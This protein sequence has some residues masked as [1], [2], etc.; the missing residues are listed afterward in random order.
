MFCNKPGL[1]A[2]RLVLQQAAFFYFEQMH[3][4]DPI[5]EKESAGKKIRG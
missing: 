1:R 5:H 2:E 3:L 4:T